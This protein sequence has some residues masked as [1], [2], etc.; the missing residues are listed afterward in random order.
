MFESIRQGRFV[1]ANHIPAYEDYGMWTGDIK[2]GIFWVDNHID[3]AIDKIRK[4]QEIIRIKHDPTNLSKMWIEI[5]N[6]LL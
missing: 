6:K 3:E 4:S 5:A 2:E 1:V